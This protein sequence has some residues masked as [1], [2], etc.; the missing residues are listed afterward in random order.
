MDFKAQTSTAQ[1]ITGSAKWA[2]VKG[3]EE[4]AELILNELLSQKKITIA[5]AKQLYQE[6]KTIRNG[7]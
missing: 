4:G 1:C 2:Y 3:I 7:L 5:I 6:I